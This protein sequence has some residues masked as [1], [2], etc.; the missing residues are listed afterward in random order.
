MLFAQGYNAIGFDDL[1]FA[2]RLA[3]AL[4]ARIIPDRVT[5]DDVFGLYGYDLNGKRR[6]KTIVREK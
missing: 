4:A 2:A 5:F 6:G 3:R 1:I